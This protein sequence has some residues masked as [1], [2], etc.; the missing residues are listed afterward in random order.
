MHFKNKANLRVHCRHHSGD[1]T[2]ACPYCGVFFAN[3]SKLIDHMLRKNQIGNFSHDE[4][5]SY[6]INIA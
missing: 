3:N 6:Y 2:A 5:R 1:K 4:E